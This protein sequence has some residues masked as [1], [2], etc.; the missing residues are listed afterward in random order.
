MHEVGLHGIAV[1]P[2]HEVQR[3]VRREQLE[4]EGERHAKPARLSRGGLGGD[5][6]LPDEP[7][8][9]AGGLERQREHVGAP[10]DAA[11]VRVQRAHLRVVHHRHLHHPGRPPHRR[12]GAVHGAGETQARHG[13][14]ALALLDRRGHQDG[15]ERAPSS[16]FVDAR[17]S[18]TPYARMIADTSRWRTTSPSS[19]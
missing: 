19:K 14:A 4:L 10:A 16:R 17:V 9:L 3:T 2:A 13:N 5:H 6:E 1:V 8:R 15:S 18:W 7:A 12:Q 11:P